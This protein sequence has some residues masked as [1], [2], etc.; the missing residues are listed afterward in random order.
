MIRD[1]KTK[2]DEM[3]AQMTEIVQNTSFLQNRNRILKLPFTLFKKWI[4]GT[5]PIVNEVLQYDGKK[6]F[7]IKSPNSNQ[8]TTPPSYPTMIDLFRPFTDA[9]DKE[10]I[11][12]EY[13]ENGFIR[14]YDGV[15]YEA[16]NITDPVYGFFNK[17]T[18][19]L[20]SQNWKAESK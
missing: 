20:A 1:E 18:P 14:T 4:S 5:T 8:N 12:G 16:Q 9:D 3:F 7:T 13:V 11:F 19:N 6:Y 10:W 17:T 15:V 2:V